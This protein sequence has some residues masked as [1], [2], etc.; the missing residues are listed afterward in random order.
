M[1]FYKTGLLATLLIGT[2][3]AGLAALHAETAADKG[4]VAKDDAADAK[5]SDA[6]K[7]AKAADCS[8]QADAKKLHGAER[9]KFREACKRK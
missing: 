4:A 3:P 6:D 7:R 5:T 2:A 1:N 8:K 9:K